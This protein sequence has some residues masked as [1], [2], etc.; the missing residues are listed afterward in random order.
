MH[1]T[2]SALVASLVLLA[3]VLMANAQTDIPFDLAGANFYTSGT[4][5]MSTVRHPTSTPLLFFTPVSVLH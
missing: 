1:C 4:A 2:T 3:A 5:S